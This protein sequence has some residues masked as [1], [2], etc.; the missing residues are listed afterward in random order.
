M[1]ASLVR[2][3]AKSSVNQ[4]LR[5]IRIADFSH[6]LP[7]PFCAR[8]LKALGAEVW[9]IELPH[10]PDP[11]RSYKKLFRWLHAGQRNIRLDFRKPDG[12]KA[13]LKFLKRADVLLEGFRPGLMDRLGLGYEA[14]R[15]KFPRLVYCSISGRGRKGPRTA[16]HDLNFQGLAGSLGWPPRMPAVPLADVAGGFQAALGIAAALFRR[17]QTGRGAYLDVSLLEGSREANV[18]GLGEELRRNPFYGLYRTSDGEWLAVA[19]LE[20]R[21]RAQLL[22]RLGRAD[23]AGLDPSRDEARIRFEL[24]EEFLRKPLKA[25]LDSLGR[26]EACVSGVRPPRNLP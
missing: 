8:Q 24:E 13:L 21:F 4:L 17:A 5:G 15:K 11:A 10:W 22:E 6:Y 25:W 20:P 3:P 23:L 26:A 2:D 14:L 16:G 18:L 9:K 1:T 12:M 7:G 19:A